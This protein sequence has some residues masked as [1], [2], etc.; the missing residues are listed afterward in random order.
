[1]DEDAEYRDQTEVSW[2]QPTFFTQNGSWLHS[3]NG[4]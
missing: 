3:N 4:K 2:A 1:M